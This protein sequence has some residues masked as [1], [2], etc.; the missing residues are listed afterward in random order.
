MDAMSTSDIDALALAGSLAFAS[1][2]TA[3]SFAG[4]GSLTFNTIANATEAVIS[5]GTSANART[6]SVAAQDA[7]DI[8]ADS[9]A[10]AIAIALGSKAAIP[11]GVGLSISTADIDNNIRAAIEGAS[12]RVTASAGQAKVSGMSTAQID[13]LTFAGA[14][15][16]ASLSGAISINDIEMDVDAVVGSGATVRGANVGTTPGVDIAAKDD[17]NIKS[18]GIGAAV[19]LGIQKLAFSISLGASIARNRVNNDVLAHVDG[20]TIV[21]TNSNDVDVNIAA[22][23]NAK[24]KATSV[25]ASLA[26]SAGKIGVAIAGAGSDAR[27][28]ILGKTNAY[29]DGGTFDATVDDVTM[30]ATGNAKIDADVV[31]VAAAL[32]VGKVGLGAAIGVAISQNLIGFDLTRPI[33]VIPAFESITSAV[34]VEVEAYIRNG[35]LNIDGD[36][37]LTAINTSDIDADVA[38]IS[39][40]AAAGKGATRFVGRGLRGHQQDRDEDSILHRWRL[41]ACRQCHAGHGRHLEN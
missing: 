33:S 41:G 37:A 24:I 35:N 15:A 34:P 6:V 5:G 10:L 13:T 21:S 32:G 12:T 17:S 9:G 29:V 8:D 19:G 2:K 11:I 7:S 36:V 26:V 38:A 23:S 3:A 1:G 4:A 25:A 31:S 16:A 39:V 30:T 14:I 40:A 27:N 28:V 18:L 22:T 20:A